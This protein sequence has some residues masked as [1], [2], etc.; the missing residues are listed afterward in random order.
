MKH[1]QLRLPQ[2]LAPAGALLAHRRIVLQKNR[3]S[4]SFLIRACPRSPG[5]FLDFPADCVLRTHRYRR[6]EYKL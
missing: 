1:P 2:G 5:E 4:F 6:I 3:H